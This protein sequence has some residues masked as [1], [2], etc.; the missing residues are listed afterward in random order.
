[1]RSETG[2]HNRTAE[3]LS[4]LGNSYGACI[5]VPVA[6]GFRRAVQELLEDPEHRRSIV[7]AARCVIESNVGATTR[8]IDLIA[9]ALKS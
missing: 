3:T 1:L 4:N 5:Q 8:N 7:D 2:N 6:A 9:Q